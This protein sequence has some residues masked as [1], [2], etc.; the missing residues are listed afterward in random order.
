MVMF[1]YAQLK[2]QYDEHG[3]PVF[4]HI[5]SVE[6]DDNLDLICPECKENLLIRKGKVNAHHFAHL[7][8]TKCAGADES[9][10]HKLGKYFVLQNQGI[11][12][13]TL[14]FYNSL[15]EKSQYF[16]FEKEKLFF[17]KVEDE[18][19]IK[20]GETSIIAD[21]LGY[22]N[23]EAY[24]IEIYVTHHVD[25]E[26]L[27]IYKQRGIS[28]LEI[29]LS[30]YRSC[31]F[32]KIAKGIFEEIENKN[33]LYNHQFENVLSNYRAAGEDIQL[34]GLKENISCPLNVW[35]GNYVKRKKTELRSMSILLRSF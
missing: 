15:R 19:I 26:K 6:K 5:D 29:D 22:K 1:S 27:N 24:A 34:N 20:D 18:V 33:W 25:E 2:D 11:P 16:I 23:G 3:R 4:V 21:A 9:I 28:V 31:D 30:R 13:P 12:L 7:R 32:K 8:K 10:T 14:S 17:D 35:D